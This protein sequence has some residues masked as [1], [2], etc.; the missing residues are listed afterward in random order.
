MKQ[1]QYILNNDVYSCKRKL[2]AFKG[3]LVKIV[4]TRG[5]VCIVETTEGKRFSIQAAQVSKVQ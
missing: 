1:D 5:E 3:E 2:Y 4:S